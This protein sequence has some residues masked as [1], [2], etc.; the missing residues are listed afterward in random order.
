MTYRQ[1]VEKIYKKL[2]SLAQRG[3][4]SIMDFRDYV[5]EILQYGQYSIFEDV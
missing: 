3:E 1:E 2:D 4:D 5:D